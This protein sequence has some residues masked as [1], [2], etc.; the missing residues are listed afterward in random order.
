[1]FVFFIFFYLYL[2][3][4]HIIY[5]H[6]YSDIMIQN[7]SQNTKIFALRLVPGDDVVLQ[8][9]EF[10]KLEKIFAGFIISAV[11]SLT[12]A[13]LRFANKT[14]STLLPDAFYEV[15]SLSG[16]IGCSSGHH[17]HLSCSDENGKTTGGH[18]LKGSLVYTTLELAI[19]SLEDKTFARVLE[20]KYGFQELVIYD[21]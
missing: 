6:K 3:N 7:S 17:L 18:L 4:C 14:E 1:V 12:V 21:K 5:S 2:L 19:L 13:N 11:G 10:C 16:T 20:P 8:L 15:V 9:E